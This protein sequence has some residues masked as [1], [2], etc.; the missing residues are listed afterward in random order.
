MLGDDPA[1]GVLDGDCDLLRGGGHLDVD[2]AVGAAVILVRVDGIRDE[3]RKHLAELSWVAVDSQALR[4]VD[5]DRARRQ[6]QPVRQQHPGILDQL[7]QLERTLLDGVEVAGVRLD[8]AD[9]AGRFRRPLGDVLH[10]VA[11]LGCELT[12]IVLRDGRVADRDAV[13]VDEVL[14][15]LERVQ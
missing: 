4:A 14:D 10:R 12:V 6:A 2:A 1:A 11:Q 5:G 15:H 9:V 13:L 7:R 8:A 3:V